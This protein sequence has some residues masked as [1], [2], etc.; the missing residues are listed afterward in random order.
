LSRVIDNP[1]VEFLGFLLSAGRVVYTSEGR[2]ISFNLSGINIVRKVIKIVKQLNIKRK[3][4]VLQTEKNRH[5]LLLMGV[6]DEF[7]F[8]GIK[9]IMLHKNVS[10]IGIFLRGIFLGCGI[11]STPPSYHVELRLAK[12][13]SAYFVSQMLSKM[14]VKN[15]RKGKIVYIMGRRNVESFLYNIGATNTFLYLEEDAVNKKMLNEANRKAN[16]EYANL[17]RQS[18]TSSKQ[19][20]ILKQMEKEGLLDNLPEKYREV[21]KLRMNYPF[22]PFSELSKK[23]NGRLSKQAIYY[24]LKRVIDSYQKEHDG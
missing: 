10:E 19:I 15:V 11:L 16:C 6:E 13:V 22:L 3:N 21:V 1:E 17:I 2:G 5:I 12:E 8:E 7:S 18:N 20:S 9:K 4:D 23:T 24:R 14:H